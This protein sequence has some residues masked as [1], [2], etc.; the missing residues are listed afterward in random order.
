MGNKKTYSCSVDLYC[1]YRS[2]GSCYHLALSATE[3]VRSLAMIIAAIR[4]D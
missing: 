1:V 2:A 3:R 4:M